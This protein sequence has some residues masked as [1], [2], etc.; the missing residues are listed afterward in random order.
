MMPFGFCRPACTTIGLLS[1]FPDAARSR[2]G[3]SAN[4]KPADALQALAGEVGMTAEYS[5]LKF[6]STKT[7]RFFLQ[8]AF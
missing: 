2:G 8:V 3:K 5:N 4:K 6:A 7:F 1:G